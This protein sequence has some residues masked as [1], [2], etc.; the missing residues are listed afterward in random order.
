[1]TPMWQSIESAPWERPILVSHG[2]SVMIAIHRRAGN[3]FPERWQSCDPEAFTFG[4]P[5]GWMYLPKPMR[6]KS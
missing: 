6:I 5:E 2:N 1:M 4:N 3:G